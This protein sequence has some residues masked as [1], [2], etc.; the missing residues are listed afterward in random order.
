MITRIWWQLFPSAMESPCLNWTF[1][2]Q[3]EKLR[4]PGIYRKQ[5]EKYCRYICS[6]KKPWSR[7]IQI[8]CLLR[9]EIASYA[10][11]LKYISNMSGST[12]SRRGRVGSA[13]DCRAGG[14]AVQILA[15]HLCWNMHVGKGTGCY[16][17]IIHWQM[18]HTR[19]EWISGKV[20]HVRLHKVRIR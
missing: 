12:A 13:S 17:G 8:Y 3:C 5:F 19:G 9:M 10:C 16:A 14:S 20:Y 11:P 15:S 7:C 1:Q 4:N 6:W 18:C 2:K